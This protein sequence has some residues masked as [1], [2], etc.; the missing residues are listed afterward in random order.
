VRAYDA[1]VAEERLATLTARFDAALEAL[2]VL[3]AGLSATDW[4][5][6]CGAEG[7]PVALE[8]LHVGLGLRRQRGF[9]D[10]AFINRKP[11]QFDWDETHELNA[12]IARRRHPHPDFVMRF[13]EDE[14][15]K[16]RDRLSQL[17]PADLQRPTIG[18]EGRML[19]LDQFIRGFFIGHVEG[20]TASIRD[21]LAR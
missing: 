18:Y 15:R 17:E 4:T 10:D 21:G 3:L 7:W 19:T 6:V 11:A 14:A 16:T 9:L 1:L 5:R 12:Q 13:Y 8:G 2:R 20:H